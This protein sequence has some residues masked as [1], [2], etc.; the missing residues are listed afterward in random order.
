MQVIKHHHNQ[1]DNKAHVCLCVRI[2]ARYLVRLS[3]GAQGDQ[4]R[5]DHGVPD[6]TFVP[7]L[8]HKT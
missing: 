5:A 6:Q 7:Q 3:D 8:H 4:R 2:R 1:H